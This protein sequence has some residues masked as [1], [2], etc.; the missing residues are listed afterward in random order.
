MST[1][2][3]E[4]CFE[5]KQDSLKM[6]ESSVGCGCGGKICVPCFLR[7]FDTRRVPIWLNEH[8]MSQWTDPFTL[9]MHLV[10]EFAT[11]YEIETPDAVLEHPEFE[12]FLLANFHI[13]KR[14]P[15]CNQTAVW[16]LNET[17]QVMESTGRL[18]FF[19]PIY[20]QRRPMP[21][22]PRPAANSDEE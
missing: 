21:L 5:E 14:C 11:K 13:G 1:F 7:D 8:G 15:F 19:A 22:P 20:V 16:K 12:K 9:Q 2:T 4:I 10:E 6:A 3:C 18:T 17:P